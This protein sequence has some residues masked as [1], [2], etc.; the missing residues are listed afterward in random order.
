M[1]G[2]RYTGKSTVFFSS[3]ALAITLESLAGRHFAKYCTPLQR[4]ILGYIWVASWFYWTLPIF[5]WFTEARLPPPSVV[6]FQITLSVV[7]HV[8]GH[9]LLGIL[10]FC[11]IDT[12]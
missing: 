2:V 5:V 9:W 3:Q 7:K 11:M 10:V 8:K 12:I 1:I 4:R 6:P